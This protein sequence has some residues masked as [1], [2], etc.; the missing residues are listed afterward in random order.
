MPNSSDEDAAEQQ[1]K[2]WGRNIY[3]HIRCAQKRAGADEIGHQNGSPE[4]CAI[5]EAMKN[6]LA[7]VAR[8]L[9]MRLQLS[10]C[11]RHNATTIGA[12]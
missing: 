4:Q 7:R 2:N 3:R 8:I 10:G 5:P 6:P 1:Q 11:A 9:L 12:C